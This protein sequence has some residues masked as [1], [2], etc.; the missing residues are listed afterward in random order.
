MKATKKL[1]ME[2][3]LKATKRQP[4]LGSELDLSIRNRKHFVGEGQPTK[5][6]KP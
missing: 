1:Y 3:S 4:Y 6:L 2:V 5:I